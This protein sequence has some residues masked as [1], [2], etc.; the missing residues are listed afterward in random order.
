MIALL[1]TAYCQNT[2]TSLTCFVDLH[3][4]I[5]HLT[6][7]LCIIHRAGRVRHDL[8]ADNV[9]SRRRIWQHCLR[10]ALVKTLLWVRGGIDNRSLIIALA[11]FVE[12][13]E[14]RK[15]WTVILMPF[16]RVSHL[17]ATSRG[18]HTKR[19]LVIRWGYWKLVFHCDECV[20]SYAY[21]PTPN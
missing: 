16:A 4:R 20:K 12:H 6:S 7:L 21:T 19:Q 9:I 13:Q 2:V 11:A 10:N 3:S 17:F 15:M 5:Y 14:W 18:S 8:N 1:L